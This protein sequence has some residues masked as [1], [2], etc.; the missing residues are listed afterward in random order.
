MIQKGNSRHDARHILSTERKKSKDGGN[1]SA[2]F[3]G[4]NT[5]VASVKYSGRPLNQDIQPL[6]NP[7]TAGNTQKRSSKLR[8]YLE[9]KM[10][11]G[12]AQP[13][14]QTERHTSMHSNNAQG[15]LK[16]D[17]GLVKAYSNLRDSRQRNKK[18]R[19]AKL[20]GQSMSSQ[21]AKSNRDLSADS[22]DG[23]AYLTK[24][25]KN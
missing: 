22:D 4:P 25:E 19:L 11:G 12:K 16:P 2:K 20:V 8:K 5:H 7:T 3:S 1:F 9:Q 13:V 6:D 17:I 23:K 14:G 15:H 21:S 10:S 18:D 24:E